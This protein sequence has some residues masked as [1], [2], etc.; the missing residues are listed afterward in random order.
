MAA[1]AVKLCEAD[2]KHIAVS[3]LSVPGLQ[4][5]QLLLCLSRI[6]VKKGIQIII[7][8]TGNHPAFWRI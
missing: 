8:F 7:T 5:F 3:Q 4:L 6:V 2:I 1:G